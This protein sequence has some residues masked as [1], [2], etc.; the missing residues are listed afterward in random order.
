MEKIEWV[1]IPIGMSIPCLSDNVSMLL[2]TLPRRQRNYCTI[3]KLLSPAGVLYHNIGNTCI[4]DIG[5]TF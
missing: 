4:Q 5:N 1:G 2:S 3:N